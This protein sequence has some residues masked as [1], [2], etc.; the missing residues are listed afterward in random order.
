MHPLHLQGQSFEA[1]LRVFRDHLAQR[2]Q[3]VIGFS[4]G[5]R[6]RR[7]QREPHQDDLQVAATGMVHV[8]HGVPELVAA[9]RQDGRLLRSLQRSGMSR[10]VE[11]SLDP[12][13][14]H[15]KA[16][17]ELGDQHALVA[18]RSDPLVELGRGHHGLPQPRDTGLHVA[19]RSEVRR[20]VDTN[21]SSG[22]QSAIPQPRADAEL[23]VQ[24]GAGAQQGRWRGERC[25]EQQQGV[26]QCQHPGLGHGSEARAGR[27]VHPCIAVR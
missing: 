9:G 19:V 12:F 1:T 11:H 26:R 3:C 5:R 16:T 23:M 8:L 10:I 27:W 24:R 4:S 18:E 25:Y 20:L 17:A 7:N 6:R 21:T 22:L 2:A 13:P 15:T 14:G